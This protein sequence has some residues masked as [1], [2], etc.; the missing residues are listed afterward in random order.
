MTSGRNSPRLRLK[1][2]RAVHC[3]KAVAG[4]VFFKGETNFHD[5]DHTPCN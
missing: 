3:R 4:P 1:T 2:D 5:G